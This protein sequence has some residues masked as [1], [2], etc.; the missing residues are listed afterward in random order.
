MEKADMIARVARFRFP[1]LRHRLEAERN[2]FERVR[3]SLAQQPGFQAVYFGR[4]AELEA[5][6]ISLFDSVQAAEAAAKRMNAE[7][8]LEGQVPEMLPTPESVGFYDVVHAIV[9]DR[10]PGATRLGNMTVAPGVDETNASRWVQ[11]FGEMLEGVSNLCQ[12]FLLR[13]PDSAALIALTFWTT[14]EALQA[15]GAAIGEWQARETAADRPSAFV[16]GQAFTLTDL[17]VA[18]AGVPATM[19]AV[20]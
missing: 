5:F 16:G 2:G 9:H 14:I 20:V 17:H 4:I 6:S 15:G 13:S 7:P 8:L 1:S 12:A 3:P 18:I 10:V 19:P 11:A